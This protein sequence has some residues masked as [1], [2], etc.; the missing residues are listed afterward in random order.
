MISYGFKKTVQRSVEETEERAT[1]VLK[2]HGFGVLTRIDMKE[3]LKE[4]LGVDF[5]K[6]VILGACNPPN[7]YKAVQA[8]EDIGLLLPCNL[9]VYEKDGATA[10][11]AVKPSVSMQMIDNPKLAETAQEVENQ[12]QRVIEE[13]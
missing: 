13:I 11:S 10:V 12:L 9:I 3:K 1:Q 8:E 6:Y 5:R 7:A 2:E 4:K